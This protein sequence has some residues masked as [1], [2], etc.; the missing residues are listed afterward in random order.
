MK[1]VNIG[2]IGLG[3]IGS[4]VAKILIENPRAFTEKLDR[5]LVLLGI[6]DIDI[7]TK[8]DIKLS[9][10]KKTTITTVLLK[11]LEIIYLFMQ[12]LVQKH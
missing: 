8:K 2:L 11:K 10:R 12:D 1:T 6:A 5:K 7:N 4:G 3:T 9:K